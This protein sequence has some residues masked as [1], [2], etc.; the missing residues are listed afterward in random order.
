[1]RFRASNKRWISALAAAVMVCVC[2][3]ASAQSYRLGDEADEIATI[4]TALKQLKLYS[5]GITGHYGE[6]TE[7]AVKKFQKKYALEDNGV[8]DEATRAALY[9]AAGIT[10]I[11]GSSSS[12]GASSSNSSVSSSGGTTLRYDMRSDAVLKLQQDLSKL[13]Y[14]SG[15]I[16]GHF[17]S[18]TEAAVMSFQ[19]ANGLSADGIA[20]S[21]TLAKIA[22]ALGNSSSGSS[23]NSS[24]S[25]SS[26]SSSSLLKQGTKSE[27]VRTL[28]QNLKTLGYYTGSV[29]GNFGPLTK[30][31]VYSFQKANGL[32]ADGVAG[33]KTLAAISSK[34]KGGSSSGSSNNSSSSSSSGSNSSSSSTSSL[35]NTSIT[36]Q[37]GTK[38][39]EVLKLQ[40]ML[41]SLGF[42]TGNKT[43]NFG[44]KTA[45]AVIAY[46]KSKGLT[47]DGI[48]GKKTL[49]AINADYSGSSVIGNNNGNANAPTPS[50][51]NNVIYENFY[52]WRRNYANG[53]Y[54]TVY[55]FSTGYSWKLR[56]MT[57]DAHMDAEPATA[58]DTAIMLKAFGNKTT[59]NPKPVWVTFSDGKTYI[60]STHDVPH[61]P[62]HL[63]SNNF[64]GHLCVHGPIPM[65]K[66]ESIGSYAVSHQEA[67]NEGW[68]MTQKLKY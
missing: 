56:I 33:E 14:Y 41:T 62:Q 51:A 10:Y 26:S 64:A 15:T 4:Q 67:I 55:D 21:K 13:G 3:T 29:T 52:N 63:T 9:E 24:S 8:V 23:S 7:T 12:S 17:G 43:G 61:S 38:N 2:V 39:D 65:S 44:E 11:A 27:A 37:Q 36:L 66:A 59:W 6:K 40:N 58:E 16:S 54:C 28:Q 53:E 22:T 19:K 45:D 42:Y 48:A 20:G 35:L 30:E 46:Q 68:E 34:L 60:G 31:A 49:A 47:A 18:K 57:K 32:S 5:A 50:M 25:N 1:M